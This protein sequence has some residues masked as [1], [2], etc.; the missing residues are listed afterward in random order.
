LSIAIQTLRNGQHDPLEAHARVKDM[1]SWASVAERT[2]AVYYRILATPPFGPWERLAR[3]RALGP[4]MGL[5]MCCIMAMQHWWLLLVEWYLPEEE[6]DVVPS[7]W[8]AGE[9]QSVVNDEK[10]QSGVELS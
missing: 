10:K 2:E 1:Y 8:D 7:G 5:I 6:L 9:F 4:I 3:L